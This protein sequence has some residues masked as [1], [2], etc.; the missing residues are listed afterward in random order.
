MTFSQPWPRS[1]TSIPGEIV[2]LKQRRSVQLRSYDCKFGNPPSGLLKNA[3]SWHAGEAS[4]GKDGSHRPLRCRMYRGM[5]STCCLEQLDVRRE[6]WL[7]R[8]AEYP[9]TDGEFRGISRKM[10]EMQNERCWIRLWKYAWILR[11]G[12]LREAEGV[13]GRG[14]RIL[15]PYEVPQHCFIPASCWVCIF[16]G[17]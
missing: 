16:I 1:S 14:R 10:V 7:R 9:G 5:Y 12:E 11:Y 4:R 8:E 6:F 2:K 3:L 13:D 17:P 15:E